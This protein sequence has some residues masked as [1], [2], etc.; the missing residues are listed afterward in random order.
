M[1]PLEHARWRLH[2]LNRIE[3]LRAKYGPVH[4]LDCDMD[5]DCLCP[6][7]V[8]TDLDVPRL[9]AALGNDLERLLRQHRDLLTQERQRVVEER[10]PVV[11]SRNSEKRSEPPPIWERPAW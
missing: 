11:G 10:K 6:A 1:T 4:D 7:G 2:V 3:E 9:R 5:E 8:E